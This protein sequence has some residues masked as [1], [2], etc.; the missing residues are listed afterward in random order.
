MRSCSPK[1]EWQ[2]T[3]RLKGRVSSSSCTTR[4]SAWLS[5]SIAA[6]SAPRYHGRPALSRWPPTRKGAR[7]SAS[8]GALRI[9]S[10][11]CGLARVPRHSP[12]GLTSGMNTRRSMSSWR[13]SSTS[14]DRR[15]TTLRRQA[16]TTSAPMRSSPCTPPKKPTAGSAGS[17]LPSVMAWTGKRRSPTLTSHTTRCCKCAPPCSTMRC[18]SASSASSGGITRRG[19]AS[20]A[21]G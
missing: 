4:H 3:A 12:P 19:P 8:T 21:P 2:S 5:A 14:H 17:G 1:P 10:T 15:F 16:S 18:S 13:C 11:P 6:P 20:G 7:S 9:R